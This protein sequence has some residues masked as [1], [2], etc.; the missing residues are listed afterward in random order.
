MPSTYSIFDNTPFS[1]DRLETIQD[2]LYKLPDNLNK[3]VSPKDIRDAIYSTFEN[4]VFKLTTISSSTIQYV[5][6]DRDDITQKMFFGKKLLSGNEVINSNPLLLDWN[7]N[8]VDIF[9]FNTKSDSNLSQQAT[10]LS[11]LAGTNSSLYNISPYIR[12]R[13]SIGPTLS[14]VLQFDIGNNSGNIGVYSNNGNVYINDIGFPTINETSASASNGSILSY[15]SSTGN[16]Y[17][18]VNSFATSSVGNPTSSTSI[19]GNPVLLNGYTLEMNDN[20]PILSQVGSIKLGKTF[21]SQGIVEVVREMLYSYLPPSCE[22]SVNPSVAEKGN[23]GVSVKISWKIYK[24]T[25]PIVNSIF[26]SGNVIGFTSP[27]PINTPGSSVISSNIPVAG[28]LPPGFSTNYVFS[29]SDSGGSNGNIPTTS[30]DSA[31]ITLVYPYFW[32]VSPIDANNPSQI[33]SILG[34]LN[35]S[36]TTLSNKEVILSGTGYIYF[37][38]PLASG[39]PTY[40]LLSSILDENGATVSSYTYSIYSGPGLT[41]PNSYWSNIPYYV[42]KI[43]PTTVGFPNPVSWTFNY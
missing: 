27:A 10:K 39:G 7:Q 32:G 23:L 19:L 37:I 43:G 1:S 9:F 2:V 11:I 16:L 14:Q 36:V 26:T 25:D 40:G 33:N 29:V 3:E 41:S 38:Y 35:K 13:T 28:I 12:S 30:T 42:Y 18:M 6:I 8:D 4:S 22:V 21:T 17:W 34:S 5:G 15:D 31:S 20:R 24:R